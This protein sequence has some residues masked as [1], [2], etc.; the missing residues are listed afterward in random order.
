MPDEHVVDYSPAAPGRVDAHLQEDDEH[1]IPDRTYPQ[2]TQDY[3]TEFAHEDRDI[4]VRALANWMIALAVATAVV[5]GVVWLAFR[6][7]LLGDRPAPQAEIPSELFLRQP[8][9]PEPRLIPNP[10]D[11]PTPVGTQPSEPLPGPWD[12]YRQEFQRESAALAALRLWD[13]ESN[14]P[15]LPESAVQAVVRSAGGAAGERGRPLRPVPSDSS[16]GTM[17]EDALR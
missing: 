15:Q 17:M 2:G 9:P 3:G 1:W 13:T 11:Y 12:V 8:V 16:G 4:N 7:F 14:L 10:Y 6:I 5:F